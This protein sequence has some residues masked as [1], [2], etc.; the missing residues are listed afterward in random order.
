MQS[1]W[2]S[3]SKSSSLRCQCLFR[4]SSPNPGQCL[5][6]QFIG[7]GMNAMAISA[8]IQKSSPL[9]TIGEKGLGFDLRY[10]NAS[11]ATNVEYPSPNRK[12][13]GTTVQTLLTNHKPE[14]RVR[15]FPSE[16]NGM[17]GREAANQRRTRTRC[18]I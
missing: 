1:S 5:W 12:N 18:N 17:R 4:C 7:H 6:I 2:L 10:S 15:R 16:S 8:G 13:T 3:L 14:P 9:L 11:A